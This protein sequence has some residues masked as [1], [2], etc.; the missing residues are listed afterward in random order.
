MDLGIAGRTALVCGAS[1][2]LGLAC[3]KALSVAGAQV[4]LL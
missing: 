1:E 3:A 2:G 4:V